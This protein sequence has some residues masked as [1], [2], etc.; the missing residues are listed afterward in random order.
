MAPLEALFR[1]EN[2][3]A[4]VFVS[5]CYSL[6]RQLLTR[7]VLQ[8]PALDV[9]TTSMFSLSRFLDCHFSPFTSHLS[10]ALVSIHCAGSHS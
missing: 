4:L 2:L 7:H 3:R 5:F 9:L 6:H 10:L 1:F 8:D